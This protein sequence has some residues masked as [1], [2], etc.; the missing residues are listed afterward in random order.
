MNGGQAAVPFSPVDFNRAV[1]HGQQPAGQHRD[2]AQAKWRIFIF[3][4]FFGY[5]K[6]T[7][8]SQYCHIS[9]VFST[10]TQKAHFRFAEL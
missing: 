5:A 9:D 6:T 10:R 4:S 7:T 8:K 2:G 1:P 3:Y